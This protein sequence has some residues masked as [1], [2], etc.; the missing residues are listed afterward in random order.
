MNNIRKQKMKQLT[1]KHMVLCYQCGT[2]LG[3]SDLTCPE[4]DCKAVRIV[5]NPDPRQTFATDN[6]QQGPI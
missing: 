4:C 2:I 3:P 6:R 1:S 5:P